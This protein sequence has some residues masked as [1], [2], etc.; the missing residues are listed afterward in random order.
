MI[1][2]SEIP[3]IAIDEKVEN[4]TINNN[5]FTG[6]GTVVVPFNMIEITGYPKF[7]DF[8][9]DEHIFASILPLFDGQY[10]LFYF[11][12]EL[13]VDRS[14]LDNPYYYQNDI[15]SNAY[16]DFE[17]YYTNTRKP[18]QINLINL[19]YKTLPY[20]YPSRQTRT[21]VID[22]VV[23]PDTYN[24]SDIIIDFDNLNTPLTLDELGALFRQIRNNRYNIDDNNLFTNNES[25]VNNER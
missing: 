6:T 19:N 20:T 9:E 8:S 15:L 1:I 18:F 3:Y 25:G 13:A 12:G 11:K 16:T 24:F 23:I 7:S 10:W 21:G 14:Q 4:L 22:G 17:F 2:M 5:V